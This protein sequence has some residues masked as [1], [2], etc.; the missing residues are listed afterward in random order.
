[1]TNECTSNNEEYPYE[2]FYTK[3]EATFFLRRKRLDKLYYPMF[4]SK[5][6]MGWFNDGLADIKPT[7]ELTKYNVYYCVSFV[8]RKFLLKDPNKTIRD[9]MNGV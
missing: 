7:V 6:Q 2:T 3:Q 8:V 5:Q 9:K 1:M 4:V